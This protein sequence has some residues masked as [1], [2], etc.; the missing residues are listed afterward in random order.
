MKKIRQLIQVE[1]KC[2]NNF[3]TKF[4]VVCYLCISFYVSKQQL[5]KSKLHHLCSLEMGFFLL[6]PRGIVPRKS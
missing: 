3:F 5:S 2:Y 1:L 4:D 6:L